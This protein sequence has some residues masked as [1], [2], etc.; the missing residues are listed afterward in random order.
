VTQGGAEKSAAID[1]LQSMPHLSD[2]PDI[3]RT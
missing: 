3:S 1:P 2:K